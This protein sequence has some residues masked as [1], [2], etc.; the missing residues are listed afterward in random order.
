MYLQY[1]SNVL[2]FQLPGRRS[3]GIELRKAGQT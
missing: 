1:A 2:P 3:G